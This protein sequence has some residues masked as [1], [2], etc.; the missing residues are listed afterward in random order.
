VSTRSRAV[1]IFAER[2]ASVAV[3]ILLTLHR[4]VK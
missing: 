3:M 1:Q 4:L 2:V